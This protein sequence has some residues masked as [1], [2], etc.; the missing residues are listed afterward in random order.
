M[1]CP[2]KTQFADIRN[3]SMKL[4]VSFWFGNMPCMITETQHVIQCALWNCYPITKNISV[5]YFSFWINQYFFRFDLFIYLLKCILYSRRRYIVLLLF[6]YRTNYIKTK[7]RTYSKSDVFN[8]G[9][10]FKTFIIDTRRRGIY[11]YIY[12]H[13]LTHTYPS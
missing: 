6:L 5:N 8:L 2:P 4:D 11:I 9:K 12:I 10:N 7:Q 3:D 13:T 1:P